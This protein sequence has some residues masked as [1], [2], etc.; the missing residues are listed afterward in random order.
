LK[1]LGYNQD[2]LFNSGDFRK[3]S[4]HNLVTIDG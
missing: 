4:N 2:Q 1:F 3:I